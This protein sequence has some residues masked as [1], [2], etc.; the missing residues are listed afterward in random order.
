VLPA[1]VPLGPYDWATFRLKFEGPF[2]VEEISAELA[3]HPQ[4]EKERAAK[5][6][7]QARTK[8][9]ADITAKADLF[10]N[11]PD[12][13]RK[14]AAKEELARMSRLR[15]RYEIVMEDVF[16]GVV[17]G[18]SVAQFEGKVKALTP[19]QKADARKALAPEV[20]TSAG[21]VPLPFTATLPGESDTYEQKLR[22]LAPPMIDEYWNAIAK[23][24]T[25]AVHSDPKQMHTL[26]EM[27]DLAEVSKDETD[28]VFGNYYDKAA[29]PAMKADT[30][31]RRGNLHDLWQDTEDLL[32]NPRTSSA[33]K[34]LMAQAL[35]IYFFQSDRKHVAP[36]N[37]AHNASPK[38]DRD[39]KPL[40]D[41]AKSQ[42]KIVAEMTR[43][44]HQVRKLNEIDRAWDASANPRTG[45]VN[46]QLFKPKGGATADQDFMW[47]M[48]QTLIHE[49]LHTLVHP[50]Y[51]TYAD[52]FGSSSLENNTL[53]EGMDSFLDEI[54]WANI[55]PRVGDQGLREKVE[56][57][58][59]ATLP[60]IPVRHA[61]RRRYA[62]YTQAVRLVDIVGFRNVVVAYFK[63]D[64]EK[65]GGP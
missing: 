48:F 62:T 63:G 12:Q 54:V 24:R 50:R 25:K 4:A 34:R 44:A 14:D 43:T 17:L 2:R 19:A 5:D 40:N 51:R 59:Y 28:A 35:V 36:L 6:L 27:E 52:S 30:K 45:D 15:L 31:T 61:S 26:G 58:K 10:R 29:H 55:R 53:M 46:I 37:R 32:S 49:Y 8:L 38:F 65:I 9:Q 13:T 57:P 1:A 16:A 21:G 39:D 18:E 60:P 3:R 22:A 7:G 47:D 56:G 23:D 11:E 41:E 20:R 33:Y 64:V 42:H